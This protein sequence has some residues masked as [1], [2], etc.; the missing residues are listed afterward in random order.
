M[1]FAFLSNED[2]LSGNIYESNPTPLLD[3]IAL[4]NKNDNNN[5]FL[6]LIY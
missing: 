5:N 4:F 6:F 2:S 1:D 3:D